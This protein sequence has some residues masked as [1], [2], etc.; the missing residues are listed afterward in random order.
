[1]RAPR[2]WDMKYLCASELL[3]H[4]I[5]FHEPL[6]LFK[7][8]D[9][10]DISLSHTGSLCVQ[11]HLHAHRPVSWTTL[12]PHSSLT[13]CFVQPP[14]Q[15]KATWNGSLV[16]VSTH[17]EKVFQLLWLQYDRDNSSKQTGLTQFFIL[18]PATM[19]RTEFKALWIEGTMNYYTCISF[20][21]I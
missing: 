20:S 5:T 1:M 3:A 12:P 19:L 2:T 15:H 11:P 21:Y 6:S 17:S 14:T 10:R 13:H 18:P 4:F 9:G 7:N 8:R 16:T